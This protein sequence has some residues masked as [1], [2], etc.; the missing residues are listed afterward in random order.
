MEHQPFPENL[1]PIVEQLE[2]IYRDHSRL[3][4]GT[5][6]HQ[7]ERAALDGAKHLLQAIIY[8]DDASTLPPV[9]SVKT[10]VRQ[11]GNRLLGFEVI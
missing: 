3:S 5:P 9:G 10:R 2:E 4:P 8:P 11:I 1:V 7:I 6:R